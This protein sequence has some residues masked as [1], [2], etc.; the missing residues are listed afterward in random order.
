M[1]LIHNNYKA[2][3]VDLDEGLNGMYDPNDPEDIALLRFDTYELIDGEWEEIPDGSYCTNMPA[4]ADRG[5]L[6]AG[7]AMIVN[8]LDD[9]SGNPKKVLEKLAWMSPDWVEVSQ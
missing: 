6:K 9:C 3:W 5:A 2:E 4:H 7:L 8:E 1:E